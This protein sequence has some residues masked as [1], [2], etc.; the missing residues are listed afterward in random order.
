MVNSWTERDLKEKKEAKKKKKQ[1]KIV[2]RK[3]EKCTQVANDSE[4][5]SGI[6]NIHT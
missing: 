5:A 3:T 1:K 2:V 4:R 6:Y